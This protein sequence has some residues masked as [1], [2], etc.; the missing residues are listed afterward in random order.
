MPKAYSPVAWFKVSQVTVND[1]GAK[2]G[3]QDY[4]EPSASVRVAHD[5]TKAFQ[6]QEALD[7]LAAGLLGQRVGTRIELVE[8]R[9]HLLEAPLAALGELECARADSGVVTA[10]TPAP[11]RALRP[12]ARAPSEGPCPSRRSDAPLAFPHR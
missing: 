10:I 6:V 2:V 3:A 12:S 11:T 4:L 1:S 5:A 8:E 7:E 9:G